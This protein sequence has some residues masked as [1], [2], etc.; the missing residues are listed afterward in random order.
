VVEGEGEVGVGVR[1]S[2]DLSFLQTHK[3]LGL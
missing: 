1:T 2:I 3:L